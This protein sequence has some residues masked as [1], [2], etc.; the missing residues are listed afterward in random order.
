M[1]TP[2]TIYVNDLDRMLLNTDLVLERQIKAC[3]DLDILPAQIIKAAAAEVVAT[4]GSFDL[5]KYLSEHDVEQHIWDD[6]NRAFIR[7]S[8]PED[9]LY[10][11]AP[12]FLRRTAGRFFTLT[13][14]GIDTQTV[15][16]QVTE[17]F[18]HPYAI[19]D[20]TC[21]G[22]LIAESRLL[23]GTFV[24]TGDNGLTVHGERVVLGEDKAL[25]IAGLPNDCGAFWIQRGKNLLASQCGSVPPQTMIISSLDQVPVPYDYDRRSHA[26]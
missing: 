9:L 24:M 14:G 10:P 3:E 15:K 4:A 21:K 11:D 13:K 25:G 17:L 18:E 16:L 1:K 7:T 22:S 5:H 2:E 20:E 23:D 8:R 12:A 19:V 26:A 6:I